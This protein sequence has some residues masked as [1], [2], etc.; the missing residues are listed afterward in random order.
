MILN[1]NNLI[2]VLLDSKIKSTDGYFLSSDFSSYFTTEMCPLY[3]SVYDVRRLIGSFITEISDDII[4]QL[5]LEWSITAEDISECLDNDKWE[6]YANKWITYKVALIILYNTEEFRKSSSDKRFK[7]LGDFSISEGGSGSNG[8]GLSKMIDWLECEVY[9][10]ELSIRYCQP[11]AINCLGLKDDK[12]AQSLMYKP[13]PSELTNKGLKDPNRPLVG[14]RCITKMPGKPRGNNSVYLFGRK[15][16]TNI[17][18][19]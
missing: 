5:I 11:P 15:Y 19:F 4:N 17:R 3:A 8:S 10:Y 13:R 6:R 18:G 9:K 2:E 14:R 12:A 16:K 1:T 7:Q